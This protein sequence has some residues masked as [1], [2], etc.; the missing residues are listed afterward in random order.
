MT[1][2]VDF[3]RNVYYAG[4]S[5]Y[6]KVVLYPIYIDLLAIAAI[7]TVCTFVG[8]YLFVKNERNR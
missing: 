8:T 2:A 5:D 1:Y 3:M 6:S 4:H 7:F